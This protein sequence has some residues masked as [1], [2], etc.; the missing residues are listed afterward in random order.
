[1]DTYVGVFID[2]IANISEKGFYQYLKHYQT[3]QINSYNK[4]RLMKS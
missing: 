2:C 1:M 3:S 4:T